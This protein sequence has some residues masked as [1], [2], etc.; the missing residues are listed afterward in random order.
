MTAREKKLL[1][2]AIERAEKDLQKKASEAS[3]A[4]TAY[5]MR[6]KNSAHSYANG[7]LDA[8]KYIKDLIG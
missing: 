3:L 1:D 2:M 8:L 6:V 5:E 4:E 7:Y